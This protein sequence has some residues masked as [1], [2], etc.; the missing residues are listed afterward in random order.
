M[1]H[2]VELIASTDGRLLLGSGE[3]FD[4]KGVVMT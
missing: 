4:L 2:P 1:P 3:A